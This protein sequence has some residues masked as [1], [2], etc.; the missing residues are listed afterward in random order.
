GK[1]ARG[2][3][4][5]TYHGL[6]LRLLGCSFAGRAQSHRP[7]FDFNALIADAVKLLRGEQLP[8]GLEPDE[9]RDRLLAGYQYILV[10][11]YQDIDEPQYEM[12]RAIA[13]RTIDDPDLKLSILAVG[14]DDQ[15]IYTFRGANV[16]FI[17]RFQ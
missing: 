14:D 4:V 10:D 6:A 15:N 11:E 9:V 13:G 2:V 16:G 5:L 17:R 7:E 8:V 12:I 3:T 1:D